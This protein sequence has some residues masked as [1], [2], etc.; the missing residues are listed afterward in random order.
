MSCVLRVIGTAFD[1]DAYLRD[2]RLVA[3]PVFRRGEPRLPGQSDGPKRGASGFNIAVSDAGVNDLVAQVRDALRFL[4][5]YEDDLRRLG[6]YP[7]VEEM[8]LDF[9]IRRRDVVAQSD[10][11]PAE[12]LWHAGA[13]DIDLVVTHYAIAEEES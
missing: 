9:A 6:S 5:E 2:S 12:L 4:G 1:V 8:C 13:L 3:A 10:L 11:F 7:G